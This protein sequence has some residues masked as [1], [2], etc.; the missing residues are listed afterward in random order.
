MRRSLLIP[1][2]SLLTVLIA[3]A[4]VAADT[5][6]KHQGVVGAHH[7]VD[8]PNRP[9]MVCKMTELPSGWW[10]M[11]GIS[12]R[13]PQV[14][15]T[16]ADQRV[17]W[18]FAVQRSATGPWN[19]KTIYQSRRQ[20]GTASVHTPASFRRMSMDVSGE[21]FYWFRVRVKMFWYAPDRT[22]EG[23]AVHA[24]DYYREASTGN[25]YSAPC[26]Y[27]LSQPK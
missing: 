6:L 27:H 23:K 12:V 16:R 22:I 26:G 19:W 15:G 10:I 24:I 2:V 17:A 8:T 9:G 4:P 14:F 3:A 20:F 21:D 5:P 18:R 7:L 25:T 11:D 1:V 13:P